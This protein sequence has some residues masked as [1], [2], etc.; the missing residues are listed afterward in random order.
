MNRN[1][2]D[3]KTAIS[4]RR[5]QSVAAGATFIGFVGQT[6]IQSHPAAASGLEEADFPIWDMHCHMTNLPGAT[7]PERLAHLFRY[8]DRL[9]I[10]RLVLFLGIPPH[11]ADPSPEQLVEVNNQVLEALGPW[12][13]RAVGFA[14]VNPN[15]VEASLAE[16]DRCIRRG[17]MAGVKLWIAKHCDADELDP[18]VQRATKLKAVVFQHTWL[19]ATGNEPGESTPFDMVKLAARHPE[20]TLICGHAGGDWERGIRAIRPFA[21][22]TL[23]I[24]GFDPT[25]GVVEMAVRELGSERVVFGSDA[26]GRSFASQLA[27][28]LGADISQRAKRMIL[29]DNI[30]RLLH[31]IL[32]TKGIVE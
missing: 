9:G 24:S 10:A 6:P 27:K 20:A 26:G 7:P 18:I 15:H 31:P 11:A 5:F 19:K 13:K 8:A 17:P 30:R 28:V 25:A 1:V 23:G 3:G 29:S 14:Y 32:Q 22:V 4:R 2:S 16:M 12:S 21:N